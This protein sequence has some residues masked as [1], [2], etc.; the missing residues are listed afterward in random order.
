MKPR[1]NIYIEHA[2]VRQLEQAAARAGS[3][4]SGMVE[5]ALVSFFSPDGGDRREAAMARR[6]DRLTRQY[7]RLERN[8]QI[9]LE[10]LALFVRHHLTATAPL[11]PSEQA[12]ALA[13]GEE[14]F[15]RFIEQ[16][17]RELAGGRSLVR[18]VVDEV[19]PTADDFFSAVDLET[20]HE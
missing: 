6:L 4:K 3:S 10:T 17:G 19:L 13:K 14:R 9:T 18:D 7:G 5:A 2:L 8:Q 16:L 20:G 11:P 15:T 12:A 1:L